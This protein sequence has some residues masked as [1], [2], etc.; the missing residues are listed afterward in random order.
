MHSYNI[1][2]FLLKVDVCFLVDCTGSMRKHI[3]A[4][5][6]NVQ[7]LRDHLANEYKGCDLR[8]SFVRYT[9]YDQPESTR[10]TYIDFTRYDIIMPPLFYV[11]I[12]LLLLC[13]IE[14]RLLLINLL[15][16]HGKDISQWINLVASLSCAAIKM[17]FD[18]LLV[19]SELVEAEI[20]PKIS[21]EDSRRHSAIYH[22]VKKHQRYNIIFSHG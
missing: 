14:Y 15:F 20:Q 18:P 3:N 8:F 2:F 1:A 19:P 22:G 6:N 16:I 5:K 12:I 21:W 7:S 13:I 4:V 10:T 11:Y 9:D 17:I